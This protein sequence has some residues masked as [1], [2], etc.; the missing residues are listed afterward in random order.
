M[1]GRHYPTYSLTTIFCYVLTAGQ[2]PCDTSST[3]KH[4]GVS[5]LHME[6]VWVMKTISN[7]W[8]NASPSVQVSVHVWTFRH[9]Y[10][11]T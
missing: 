9:L 2:Q 10:M 1:L 4:G 3:V 5:N 11:Y 8:K 6:A 7:P